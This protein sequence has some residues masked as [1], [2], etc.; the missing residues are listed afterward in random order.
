MKHFIGID[1][2]TQSMKGIL[3]NPEGRLL[4]TK[5]AS[6]YPDFP[7]ANWCEHDA[8]AWEAAL[9]EIV[10]AMVAEAG[11]APDDVGALGFASQC[12]GLVPVGRD[13]NPVRKAILWLDR[14]AEPQCD[15]IRSHISDDECLH[16]IGSS[17]TS[18]LRAP[19]ILWMRE[20]E[21]ELYEKT[22]YFLEVGEYMVYR[23]TGALTSDYA[24]TSIT[25]LF[26]VGKKEWSP[27]MLDITGISTDTLGK[28]MAAADMAGTL[29]PD[30]AK[31][32][33]LSER[34]AV[35]VGSGDQHAG[36][37]GS[38]LVGPGQILNIMGTSEIVAGAFDHPVYDEAKLLKTHLHVDPALWQIEQGSLISGACVRWYVDNVAR[39]GYD[40]LNEGAAKIPAGS[41][42]LVFF[43]ALSGSN[44]PVINGYARG[45]FFGLT[46]SHTLP[47]MTR[48]LY[49]GNSY[50][51][52]DNIERLKVLGMDDC[53]IIATGGGTRSPVWMQIKADLVG[54]PIQV[55]DNPE[56]TALGAAM[57]AGVALGNFKDFGQAANCLLKYGRV[58]EPD[59][60][61]KARYDEMYGLYRQ[62]YFANEPV[63]DHYK[64]S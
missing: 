45:I 33:G 29:L 42:G 18:T 11:I 44:S 64:N 36:S 41:D 25:A 50:A 52:R 37:I 13:G 54:M 62:L 15:A 35:V 8:G 53:R 63:F 30:Q 56:P 57:L 61:Q 5:T 59:P 7:R 23:L 24:H 48:A 39:M 4:S 38:G 51:F 21:P 10:P 49:E 16:L 1:L 34:T 12:G 47:H 27:R 17:V 60:S 2:G 19:K 55:V 20:N 14:R 6:Y 26:D 3:L 32:L 46:M 43:P 22:A 40:E 9:R 28:V 58:Y 31:A